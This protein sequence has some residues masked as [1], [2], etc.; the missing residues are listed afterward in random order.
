MLE[1]RDYGIKVSVVAPGGVNTGFSG[2]SGDQGWKLAP[3]DVADA[4][5][6][7]IDTP[8]NVLVHRVEVRTLTV[9]K[10]KSQQ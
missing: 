7:V 2:G 9:P 8:P 1:L 5:Y 6:D 4:V 3:E 10:K